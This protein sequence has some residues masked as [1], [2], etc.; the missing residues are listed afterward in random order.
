MRSKL[1]APLG[2]ALAVTASAAVAGA[3]ETATSTSG[4]RFPEDGG[5]LPRANMPEGGVTGGPNRAQMPEGGVDD[6]WRTNPEG[7]ESVIKREGA[8]PEEKHPPAPIS[9]G[10][11]VADAPARARERN[12]GVLADEG[13][14]GIEIGNVR[15]PGLGLTIDGY[16]RVLLE[17]VENDAIA[18]IG[19][20]DGFHLGNARIGF[21][22]NYGESLYA[23]L[24]FELAEEETS[25]ANDASPTFV[26]EP[27][28]L[29]L[30]YE[31]SNLVAITAGRFK[32]PYDVGELESTGQRVFIDSPIESRGVTR[33]QGI[34]QRGMSQGRQ[35]GIMLYQDRLGLTEN[36]FDLGYAVALTNGNTGDLTLNDNDRPAAFVRLSLHWGPWVTLNA[37]GFLDTRTTG[38]LPNRFDEDVK[39]FE[40]SMIVAIEGLRVEGQFLWQ[41][42]DYVTAM[43]ESNNAFGFHV[44]WSYRLWGFE[45]A[46]RFAWYDPFERREGFVD[47]D[48]DRV[49]EHTIGLSYFAES[50][51]LR[52]SLN[53]TL[54]DEERN[55]SNNRLAALAQFTF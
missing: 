19:R 18:Y 20:N 38:E 27:K 39:G 30:T 35:L 54:A 48:V 4:I 11:R 17:V 21:R 32:A 22:P 43:L 6:S 40:G 12:E 26:V 8:P 15:G 55:L 16:L 9:G 25:G 13:R 50:W 34:E 31:L 2:C 24:S 10:V 41:N 46:Y 29:Y 49:T 44:Q 53:G 45:A 23:Y 51:P 14:G 28:D 52:F 1:L 42:T 33:L 7:P 47:S 5:P 37:G 36:A 3:A